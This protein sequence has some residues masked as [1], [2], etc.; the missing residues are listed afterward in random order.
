MLLDKN[1]GNLLILLKAYHLLRSG[2]VATNNFLKG[3]QKVIKSSLWNS[4]ATQGLVEKLCVHF[5]LIL[6]IIV[7][8]IKL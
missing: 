2:D 5:T 8:Q 3:N 4:S 1:S 7:Q 6:P